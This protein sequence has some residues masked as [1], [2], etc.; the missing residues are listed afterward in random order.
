MER[1]PPG[2][3]ILRM[4]YQNAHKIDENMPRIEY[5]AHWPKWPGRPTPS[6]GQPTNG[7]ACLV[8]PGRPTWGLA[9]Q[10]NT[11]ALKTNRK[12]KHPMYPKAENTPS[13]G[14]TTSSI[15]RK[16]RMANAR[17]TH[18]RPTS[19]KV[20]RPTLGGIFHVQ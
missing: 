12:T 7:Q 2:A 20:G 5:V 16:S 19:Y 14:S 9:A 13:H 18:G 15:R 8:Q 17:L 1:T 3:G 10:Q 6:P 11:S 4:R